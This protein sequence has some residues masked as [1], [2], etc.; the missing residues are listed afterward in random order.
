LKALADAPYAFGSTWERER[1][2]TEQQWRHAIESRARFVADLD[3]EVVGMAAAGESGDARAASLTSLWVDHRARGTG[4]GDSLVLA[5]V[6]WAV[7]AGYEQVI[8]W[9]T[10]GNTHAQRL[11]E[12]HGFVR[13]GSVQQVRPGEARLEFEMARTL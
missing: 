3:G 13:T 10:D 6:A 8:L 7:K 4:L 11:Y 5:A 9:V 2:N 1:I 12:R